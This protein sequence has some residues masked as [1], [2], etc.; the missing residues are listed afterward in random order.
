[1]EMVISLQPCHFSSIICLVFTEV[2]NLRMESPR[3]KVDTYV[4]HGRVRTEKILKDLVSCSTFRLRTVHIYDV[5]KFLEINFN[6]C[7]FILG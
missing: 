6:L 5:P 7:L 3:S 2:I 4:V 1:M